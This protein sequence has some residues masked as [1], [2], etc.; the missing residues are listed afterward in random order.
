ME[1]TT[2]VEDWEDATDEDK[3]DGEGVG[4][5]GSES[6]TKKIEAGGMRVEDVGGGLSR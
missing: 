6:D 5:T 3:L 2:K 1:D 4:E